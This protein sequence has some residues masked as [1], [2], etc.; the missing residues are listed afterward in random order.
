MARIRS[1]LLRRP[2]GRGNWILAFARHDNTGKGVLGRAE[3]SA[4]LE[5]LQ[6]SLSRREV[7]LVGE[8]LLAEEQ[9]I[10][11]NGFNDALS[12][13][14][15]GN[16]RF[17]EAWAL[18]A[19]GALAELLQGSLAGLACCNMVEAVGRLSPPHSELDVETFSAWLP[20][21]VEG[22]TDWAAAEAWRASA[23]SDARPS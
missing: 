13:A 4:F 2:R 20:K 12:Y 10:S 1:T 22:A 11:V 17:N 23:E 19:A 6:L 16:L 3:F 5:S 15:S 14:A 7:F 18:Q 8:C 21:D 9:A